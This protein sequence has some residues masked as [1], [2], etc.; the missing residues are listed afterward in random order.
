MNSG[1]EKTAAIMQLTSKLYFQ[2]LLLP[3]RRTIYLMF[4]PTVRRSYIFDFCRCSR[5]GVDTGRHDTP[6]PNYSTVG[7]LV[8][9]VSK[10]T[11][12]ILPS[13]RRKE[14]RSKYILE[15]CTFRRGGGARATWPAG[16]LSLPLRSYQLH[17]SPSNIHSSLQ[18]YIPQTFLYKCCS[19]PPSAA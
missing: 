4:A 9:I 8:G 11:L 3:E 19:F 18:Q 16:S 15:F 5:S 1:S 2:S 17:C 7:W 12:R 14:F 10:V 13:G 6:P